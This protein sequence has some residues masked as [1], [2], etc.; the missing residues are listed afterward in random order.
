MARRLAGACVENLGATT[1][2]AENGVEALRVLEQGGVDVVL[3]DM[4]MPEM[5]GLELTK[6]VSETYPNVPVVLMTAHGSEEV[7]VAALR[8]GAS[9]YVPK[10][11]MRRDLG[12]AL[13]A[14]LTAVRA[15]KQWAQVRPLLVRSESQYLVGY[16]PGASEALLGHL[17]RDLTQIG[18]FD[19]TEILGVQTSLTEAL[20]NA[21]DHG[22]LELDSELRESS[23]AEYRA[24]GAERAQQEPYRDRRV[25]VTARLAP[26]EVAYVIRDEGVG[27]DISKLPDPRDPENLV[28][29]SGRGV[30]MMRMFM[31]EVTWNDSGNEVT[32]RLSPEEA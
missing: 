24:L 5:D 20:R 27:F 11:N 9:N 7:A 21:I 17:V 29:A 28:R 32:M 2:E 1:C 16:E 18:T 12:E 25:H 26:E 30:L 15:A 13:R 22:N 23:D 4:Q 6:R 31:D 8:A 3:T 19:E 14:V 10:E